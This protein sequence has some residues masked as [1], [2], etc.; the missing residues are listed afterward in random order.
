M[1]LS[2]I[3]VLLAA[4]LCLGGVTQ[5]DDAAPPEN[6]G[7]DAA[8]AESLGADEYGMRGYV[9]AILV[10]GPTPQPAGPDRDAMFAGHFANMNRLADAG[11]LILAGPLDGVDGRR[12]IFVLAAE[13]IEEAR[14]LVETDPV[15]SKGEMR[16]EYHRYYGS[17]ALLLTR[18][19]HDRIARKKF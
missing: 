12:G 17:A 10:N 1:N 16:A 7:Y 2:R 6:P 19:T 15:I 4:L 18:D 5:A 13:T 11:K 9:L 8:L 3:L 14:E